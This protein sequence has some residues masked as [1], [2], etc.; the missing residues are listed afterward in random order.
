MKVNST[1]QQL[2][3]SYKEIS[4]NGAKEIA[5]ALK[6]NSTLQKLYLGGNEI[7]N[8]GAKELADAL[9]GNSTLQELDLNGRGVSCFNGETHLLY[10]NDHHNEVYF[11]NCWLYII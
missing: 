3:L 11:C 8:N 4:N 1:L 2:G 10:W 9:K 6:V 5:D 7:S